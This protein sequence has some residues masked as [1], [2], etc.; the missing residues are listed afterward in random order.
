MTATLAM[1]NT[2]GDNGRQSIL[3]WAQGEAPVMSP[4]EEKLVKPD[5]KPPDPI[6]AGLIRRGKEGDAKAMEEIYE[7]FKSSFF[8]L[9]Y[10]YTY[11]RV[12][13]EDLL[14][15]IFIKILTHLRDVDRDETFVSWMYRIAINECYSYLRRKR[16]RQART[17]NLSSIEGKEEEA[18]YD[19]HERRV[20]QS[21]D[22]AIQE[23][24][25]K[26]RAVF[27]LH[28]VQGFK[29][30]EVAATLGIEVGTSKSQL[31]KARLKIREF[32]KEK[33]VL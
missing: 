26:L 9:A 1:E 6:L 13:A 30:E 32:L 16:S 3:I 23:L 5:H 31:F 24:P 7:R 19:S 20:R 28:D 18:V 11:D 14:Q 10:R 33:N 21:I 2:L 25:D 12:A 27:V 8:N 22:E 4:G 15:D 29:H 17:V